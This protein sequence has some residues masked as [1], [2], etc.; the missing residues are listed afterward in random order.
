MPLCGVRGPT[1]RKKCLKSGAGAL[2]PVLSLYALLCGLGSVPV[3][4]EP[5][6]PHL[7]SMTLPNLTSWFCPGKDLIS[8]GD[9]QGNSRR[10]VTHPASSLEPEQIRDQQA[11]EGSEPGEGELG[12]SWEGRRQSPQDSVGGSLAGLLTSG[13]VNVEGVHPGPSALTSLTAWYWAG[14]VSY[15]HLTLPTK[16]HQCRSRWSPYH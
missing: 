3:S 9:W 14:P 13:L 2:V 8:R 6:F 15:T 10:L 12:G 4:L 11:A 7:R 16:T 1:P 5:Q